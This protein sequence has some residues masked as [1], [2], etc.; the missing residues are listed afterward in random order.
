MLLE[1]A[2]IFALVLINGVLAGAEIAVV[3]LRK[4]RVEQ[5]VQRGS[6]AAK[7]VKALQ[8]NPERFL[9]TVQVGITVVSAAAGAFGGATMARD[10]APIV[11]P[12]PWVGRYAHELALAVVISLVSFL[13]IVLGELVP[14][15]LALRSSERYA[16]VI[17][18]ALL[19][20][21]TL[22]RPFV[23]LL[24]Q[25]SNVVL[26]FFGDST[27]F[28]EARL[29]AEEIQQLVG[30][31][32]KAG[33]VHPT[34]GEIASRA[35]DFG[36]LTAYHVMVP[37][38]H[39]VAVSRDATPEEIQRV[40]LEK[41]HTRMPVYK[42]RVENVVGYITVRDVLAL[43]WER[44]LVVL[45]DAIRPALF[46]PATQRAV[47]LLRMLR[48]RGVQLAIVVDESGGMLGIVTLED[49]VEELVGEIIDE[50]G[51][52]PDSTIETQPDGALIA[53][54]T[55]PIREVNRRLGL[56]LPDA[57]GRSTLG[58]LCTHLVG[59]IPQR[60][61]KMTHTDGTR[62]E[63]IE[64]SPRRVV[65]VRIRPPQNAGS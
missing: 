8:S 65:R 54:A 55:L 3:S 38:D 25:S 2:V 44:G 37:R 40:L 64:A 58:G 31:A 22:A 7:A 42:D 59:R 33:S 5:L 36:D 45:D 29:S 15:S 47:D 17:G 4:T 39:V 57:P 46:V 12:L 62:I 13:S 48:E 32:A 21:S 6:H 53:P 43:F 1:V 51:P 24:T 60:G 30:E 50:N 16:L 52:A 34:L 63:V 28:T 18:R 56:E 35:L 10:L 61:E 20:L 9:A 23:W 27:T 26:R 41:G 14:K 19:F 11:A 49:L